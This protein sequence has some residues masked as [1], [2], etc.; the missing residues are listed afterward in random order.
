MAASSAD[1]AKPTASE[2]A[3]RYAGALFDLAKDKSALEAVAGDLTT[4]AGLAADS[5]DLMRLLKSPAF[6]IEDKTKAL[7]AVA[8]KAKLSKLTTG[9]IGTM[10]ENGRSADLLGAASHFDTLYA[11]ERGVKRAIASTAKKMT[12]AQRKKL[13][14]VLTKAVGSDIELETQVDPA[15]VGGIQLRI[16]STLIDASI[17]AKLDRMNTAMK[18]A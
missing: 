13:E 14:G 10:A 8:E 16:G 2:A 4:F 5:D 1:T 11:K 7:V 17:A 9:F 3:R 18:G 6:T 12:A 15:L